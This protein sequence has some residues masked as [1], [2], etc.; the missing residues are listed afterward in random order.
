M[1]LVWE[2]EAL[3][4]LAAAADWS[5]PQAT[6]AVDA[7]ERMADRGFSLGRQLAGSALRYWPVPP[8]AVVYRITGNELHV[9]AVVDMRRLREL[10]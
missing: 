9:E 3:G 4:D 6:A 1:R 5:A 10:P 2:P 8:L 7:I